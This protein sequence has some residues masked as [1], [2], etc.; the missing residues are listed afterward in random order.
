MIEKIQYYGFSGEGEKFYTAVCY[1]SFGI[2]HN[3]IQNSGVH[4]ILNLVH[5]FWSKGQGNSGDVFFARHGFAGASKQ[6][7]C[8]IFGATVFLIGKCLIN[9]Q[10]VSF[11]R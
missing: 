11:G 5:Q 10:Q 2:K 3:H 1:D 6:W 9:G 8:P 7:E 4:G